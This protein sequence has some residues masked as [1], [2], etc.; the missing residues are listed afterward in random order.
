MSKVEILISIMHQKN[1]S[2]F[3]RT[4]IKTEALMIDQCD[5]DRETEEIN[6]YGKLRTLTTKERGLSKS[7]NMALKKAKGMYCLI[8]DD[9][10]KLYDGYAD[11]IEKAYSDYPDAE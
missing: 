11:A 10:E 5:H 2:L 3:Y 9:D 4:G 1:F 6:E 8:C 7:H